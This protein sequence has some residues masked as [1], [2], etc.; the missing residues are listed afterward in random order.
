[1][2][3]IRSKKFKINFILN[4]IIHTIKFNFYSIYNS[5]KEISNDKH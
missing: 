5:K 4:K 3:T 2:K 1:M